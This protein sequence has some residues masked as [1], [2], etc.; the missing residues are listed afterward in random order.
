MTLPPVAD[1]TSWNG[2]CPLSAGD[3]VDTEAIDVIEI[4][5]AVSVPIVILRHDFIVT[6]FNAAAADTLGLA[7]AH[8]GH[9]PRAIAILSELENLG[10]W[11]AEAIGTG[12]TTQHDIRAADRSFIVRIAPYTKGPLT[13]TVLTFNN[14]TAFRASIDQ[15]VYEREYA[16]AILNTVPDALV[17][18]DANLQVLTANRAFHTIFRLSRE[19]MQGVPL[20]V[21]G[22]GILDLAPL[23]TQLKRTLSD[24]RDFPSFEI[25]CYWPGA[26]RRTMSLQ[27]RRFALPGR[28]PNMVL[29]NLHDITSRKMAEATNTRLAAIVES[30]DD[31]ILTNDVDGIITSWNGAAQRIFGYAAEEIIGKPITLLMPADRQDEEASILERVKRGERIQPYD[32]VR[33]R[34]G[35]ALVDIFVTISALKDAGGNIYGASKIARD[36]T[37]RKQAEEAQRLLAHEV[38]HRSKNLLTLVQA[39]VHFSEADTPD[40]IKA[41]IEGRIQALANVH[42][43]LAQSHWAGVNLRSIVMDELFPYC[44]LGNSRAEA[45]GPDLLLKPQLAQLIAMVLHELT[46]NAVKYGALSVSAGRLRVQWSHAA[47]GNLGIRWTERGGPLVRSPAR[48]GFGSRMLDRAIRTQLNGDLRFN[49]QPEGL[50]CEIEVPYEAAAPS[51]KSNDMRDSN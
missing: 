21:L 14:V 47:N 45:D 24:D 50:V 35:G 27:A 11:C 3:E 46:T 41:A 12:T 4:L 17:V 2:F 22:D 6:H 13:G 42:T 37:D 15:A 29:L 10:R 1:S 40:A 33:Q 26:G 7:A 9:S 25:D 48:R 32:T 16:K 39:A 38:D 43:L 20:N 30:S 28:S 19:A 23:L 34:K 18:L 36:I 51:T 49:W 31:A 5:D 44:P 8:I